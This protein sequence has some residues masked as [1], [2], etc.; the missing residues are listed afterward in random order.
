M[1]SINPGE[2]KVYEWKADYAGVFMYHCGTTPTLH[3]IA[4]GMYGM[5]IVE[6]K[7]GLEPVEHEYAL[8]QSEWYLGAQCQIT[9]LSKASAAAADP[10]FV[11]FNGVASQYVDA[12]IKV[13]TGERPRGGRPSERGIVSACCRSC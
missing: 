12:P 7:E 2:E 10:D 11:V 6:P 9:D 4:N 13:P 3:H 8:V 5:V 1:T